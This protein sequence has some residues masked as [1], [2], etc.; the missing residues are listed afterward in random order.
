MRTD[1]K[2]R[3]TQLAIQYY[4]RLHCC[5]MCLRTWE[6]D[7][8]SKSGNRPRKYS[9]S[10]SS[11]SSSGSRTS[12]STSEANLLRPLALTSTILMKALAIRRSS[13]NRDLAV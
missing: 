4:Y 3:A 9:E 7:A 11:G 12:S 8:I 13:F 1:T 5:Y 2:S 6:N 10:S